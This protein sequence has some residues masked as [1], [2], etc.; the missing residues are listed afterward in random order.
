M[1]KTILCLILALAILF[2]CASPA[3]A[4]SNDS[5]VLHGSG[6]EYI[7]HNGKKYV[8]VFDMWTSDYCYYGFEFD[9]DFYYYTTDLEYGTEATQAIYG[10]SSAVV[11][12]SS[13][14]SCVEA[15][16]PGT[17]TI[18]YV[19]EGY[20]NKFND[21]R[22]CALESCILKTEYGIKMDFN[23]YEY[24]DT[25]KS[26][27]I[28]KI[29]NSYF[30]WVDLYSYDSSKGLSVLSGAVLK[31]KR[32][33][34]TYILFY[35]DFD[36][37]YFYADGSFAKLDSGKI[38]NVYKIT[39]DTL[40][41]RIDSLIDERPEDDLDWLAGTEPGYTTK[42]ISAIFFFGVIPLGLIV[43]SAIMLK[44]CKKK[45]YRAPFIVLMSASAVLLIT[46]I[47]VY[48]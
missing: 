8:A 41:K 47:I 42:L 19:A 23:P 35:K 5:W 44:K 7:T 10:Y 1:K 3:F 26:V 16:L 40:I 29:S 33:D 32:S 9:E 2:S 6:A 18:L 13:E 38:Y 48:V 37:S 46:A 21:L 24:S 20:M 36:S 34:D 43:F 15:F 27:T 14:Y 25:Y 39:D 17:G 45:M 30:D 28:T 4:A 11:Y 12:T 22:S 31:S